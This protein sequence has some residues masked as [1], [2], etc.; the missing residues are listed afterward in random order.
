M[1]HPEERF[2]RL[3]L[4]LAGGGA[5]VRRLATEVPPGEQLFAALSASGAPR[6]LVDTGPSSITSHRRVGGGSSRETKTGL[7]C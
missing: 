7:S 5:R 6:A 1:N 4:V 3:G 2:F